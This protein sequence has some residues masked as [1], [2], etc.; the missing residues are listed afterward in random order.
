MTYE[1]FKHYKFNKDDDIRFEYPNGYGKH[2]NKVVLT[3]YQCEPV[4]EVYLDNNTFMLIDAGSLYFLESNSFIAHKRN[5]GQVCAR[6]NGTSRAYIHR[7]ILTPSNNLQ[8]DHINHNPLDNRTS[9]LRESSA[10]QN[11]IAK[12]NSRVNDTVDTAFIG[13]VHVNKLYDDATPIY[14]VRHPV[15]GTYPKTFN[16]EWEAAEYRDQVIANY[17]FSED[18][19]GEW[20]TLN[21]IKWNFDPETNEII[22]NDTKD[23]KSYMEE[24]CRLTL[25]HSI[26]WLMQQSWTKSFYDA[27]IQRYSD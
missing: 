1:A 11:N 15:E 7:L 4:A 26:E 6:A 21:F 16:C 8:V 14:K 13:V 10:K 24:S 5:D 12:R 19:G 25:E 17:F 22:E 23:Y 20:C 18:N 3:T 9:N 27:Y 2:K